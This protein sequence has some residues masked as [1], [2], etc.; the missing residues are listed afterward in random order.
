MAEKLSHFEKI[1]VIA[2]LHFMTFSVD[3]LHKG[4]RID[5][6]QDQYKYATKSSST[7]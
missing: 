3:T 2:V 4:E 1:D 7:L 5:Y 6:L